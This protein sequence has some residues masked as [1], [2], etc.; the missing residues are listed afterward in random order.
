MKY[1][2]SQF[3]VVFEND[4]GEVII[5][6]TLNTCLIVLERDEYDTLIRILKDEDNV[7]ENTLENI[8]IN[9]LLEYQIIVDSHLDEYKTIEQRNWEIRHSEDVIKIVVA[10]TTFCNFN[11]TYCYET[12]KHLSKMSGKAAIKIINA[13]LK[14][15][16]SVNCKEVQMIWYGGEPLLE[17]ETIILISSEIKEYCDANNIK[18]SASMPTNGYLLTPEVAK[19]LVSVGFVQVQITVDGLKPFHDEKRMLHNGNGTFDVI[20]NNILSTH[21]ILDIV[22]RININNK[23][24]RGVYGLIDLFDEYH[25]YDVGFYLANI[26]NWGEYEDNT[27]SLTTKEFANIETAFI[28]YALQRGMNRCLDLPKPIF[29]FCEPS[30][31]NNL[32]FDPDGDEFLCWE[33]LGIKELTDGIISNKEKYIEERDFLKNTY[34]FC[35]EECRNCNIIPFCLGGCP[36]RIRDN[37]ISECKSIKY[38]IREIIK[39]Y[40]KYKVMNANE[41]SR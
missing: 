2:L 21:T 19:E 28:D 11:C 39:L 25:I 41:Q 40:Y 10:P 6:H 23:N 29:G 15:I 13:S 35:K 37:G 16:R 33:H 22:V 17:K 4:N 24:K 38:N 32:L 30:C 9:Q 5:F 1:K 36:Q 34:S 14:K 12:K 7:N 26:R 20:F 27:A 18:F 3:L 31:V 8:F